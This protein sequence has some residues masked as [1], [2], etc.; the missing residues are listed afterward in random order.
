LTKAFKQTKESL[1]KLGCS[2]TIPSNEKNAYKAEIDQRY[3]TQ[4]AYI[5]LNSNDKAQMINLQQNE[6]NF[7]SEDDIYSQAN[8]FQSKILV[9]I[10]LT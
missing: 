2:H 1:Y 4:K 7:L 5:K 8:D 6:P 9:F 3:F 10:K